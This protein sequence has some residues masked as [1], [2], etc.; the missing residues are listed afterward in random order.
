MAESSLQH[1]LFAQLKEASSLEQ[2]SL[3]VLIGRRYTS[4]F[5]DSGMGWLLYGVALVET[6]QYHDAQKALMRAIRLCPDDR[7]HIPY[8]HLG[9]MHKRKGNLKIAAKWYQKTIAVTPDDAGGHIY[10]G[11]VLAL[12]GKLK[13]AIKC[14]RTATQCKEGCVEEAFLNLG[15]VLRAQGK[16][17]LAKAA[18]QK[19][20]S[21]DNNYEPAREALEDVTHAIQYRVP[22]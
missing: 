1:D 21:L 9:H 14:H 22:L 11:A 10:L 2:S 12:Q 17:K 4:L 8:S 20:L 15:L 7:L 18:L 6:A 19:A 13:E 5:A 3:T 16:L